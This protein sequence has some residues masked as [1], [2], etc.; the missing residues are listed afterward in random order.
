MAIRQQWQSCQ[1]ETTCYLWIQ[2]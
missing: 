2:S 1:L